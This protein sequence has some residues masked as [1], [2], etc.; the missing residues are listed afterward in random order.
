MLMLTEH[1]ETLLCLFKHGTDST[2]KDQ[3]VIWG[4][5]KYVQRTEVPRHYKL[6]CFHS[7]LSFRFHG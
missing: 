1:M 7:V 4:W 2:H 5:W 3:G 6:F